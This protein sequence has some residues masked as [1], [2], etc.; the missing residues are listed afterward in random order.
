MIEDERWRKAAG[1][2]GGPFC[3][4]DNERRMPF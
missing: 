3:Y 1:V 2:E 4:T